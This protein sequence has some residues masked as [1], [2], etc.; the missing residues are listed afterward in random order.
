MA[1]HKYERFDA[2]RHLGVAPDDLVEVN[3]SEGGIL[4][5]LSE[6]VDLLST[7]A[8]LKAR[9]AELERDSRILNVL[10]A[11]GVDNWEGY[12]DAMASLSEKSEVT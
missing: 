8:K 7:I 4:F 6:T 10:R 2:A 1:T 3:E 5:A 9:V 12:D 11:F